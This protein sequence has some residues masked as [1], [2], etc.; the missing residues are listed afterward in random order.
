MINFI[1]KENGG[2]TLIETLVAIS[3]FTTSVLTLVIMLSQGIS[4]TNY[5]KNK[6]IA[7]YLSQEGIEYVRNLRDT[8][9]VSGATAQA[10]W[11]AFVNKLSNGGC[12]LSAGCFFDDIAIFED[13][14]ITFSAFSACGTPCQVLN[15]NF[16]V[17][18]LGKYFYAIGQ[19]SGFRRV[20]NVTVVG[21]D[22][23]KVS[24][25]VYWGQ[26]SGTK[27]VVLSENLFNWSE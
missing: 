15:Y 25:T 23:V 19:S 22:E 11:N 24:S 14:S 5:A 10:G 8:Y 16:G 3:I 26:A 7:G 21:V 18:S 17:G 27:N 6:I 9:V 4:D 20:I 13:S 12:M 2:F 1:K